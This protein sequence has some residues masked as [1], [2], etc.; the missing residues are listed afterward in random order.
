MQLFVTD[1]FGLIIAGCNVV[2]FI[3]LIYLFLEYVAGERSRVYVVLNKILTP[4]L[5]PLRRIVPEKRFD[6]APLIAAVLLQVVVVALKGRL[7]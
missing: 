6:F 1:K 7:L 4:I 5:S 3:L 2:T